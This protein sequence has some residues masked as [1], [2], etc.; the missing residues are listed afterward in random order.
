MNRQIGGVA[1]PNV[2]VGVGRSVVDV[3]VE[4]AV[5]RRVVPVAA[6]NRGGAQQVLNIQL[7]IICGI[8]WL[9]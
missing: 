3:R 6:D 8:L 4:S 1:S 2:G 7:T 9:C 5:E